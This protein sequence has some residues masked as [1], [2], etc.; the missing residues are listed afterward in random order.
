MEDEQ[1]KL[2]QR[3]EENRRTCREQYKTMQ[4]ASISNSKRE[5]TLTDESSVPANHETKKILK[6][7]LEEEQKLASQVQTG[8]PVCMHLVLSILGP[9]TVTLSLAITNKPNQ[10][11]FLPFAVLFIY[12]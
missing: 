7:A 2:R 12:Y 8:I 9:T 1:R 3:I 5:K 4:R 11:V 10:T 6:A